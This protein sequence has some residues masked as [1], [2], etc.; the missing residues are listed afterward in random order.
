MED[1]IFFHCHLYTHERCTRVCVFFW[2]RARRELCWRD[3]DGELMLKN[4]DGVRFGGAR[5]DVRDGLTPCHELLMSP[6]T[7]A[8][9]TPSSF[10][11]WGIFANDQA[12]NKKDESLPNPFAPI[13][14]PNP[15]QKK[16]RDD[17]IFSRAVPTVGY[18]VFYF[19]R[20]LFCVPNPTRVCTEKT[21]EGDRGR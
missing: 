10:M 12:R 5:G 6:A 4:Q 3:S 7:T 18:L 20:F 1:R 2:V 14:F 15:G 19:A 11:A 21:A 9:S 16:N 17:Y 13:S 8:S